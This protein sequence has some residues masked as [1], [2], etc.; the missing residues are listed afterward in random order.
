MFLMELSIQVVITQSLF[1][2][3]LYMLAAKYPKSYHII[4]KLV[5][6]RPLYNSVPLAYASILVF[7]YCSPF[8]GTPAEQIEYPS[9]FCLAWSVDWISAHISDFVTHFVQIPLRSIFEVT[10]YPGTL[11]KGNFRMKHVADNELSGIHL[12]GTH[13]PTL[14]NRG[15]QHHW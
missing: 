4:P 14:F 8:W 13:W 9:T 2:T 6:Y 12:P 11:I 1:T 5:I 3:S 15:G 7:Q 10:I